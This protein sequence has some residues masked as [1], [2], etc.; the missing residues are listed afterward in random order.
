[1]PQTAA[2]HCQQKHTA[3][4]PEFVIIAISSSLLKPTRKFLLLLLKLAKYT[5]PL[6]DHIESN[7]FLFSY[8]ENEK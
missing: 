3:S 1:L 5:G 7:G 4:Y 8:E 6:R 2:N